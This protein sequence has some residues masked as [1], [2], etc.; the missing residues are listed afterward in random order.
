MKQNAD[1]LTASEVARR[2]GVTSETV[3]R[4]A[5]EGKVEYL[6]LPSGGIRFPADQEILQRIPVQGQ[7]A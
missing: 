1:L 3:R 5:R 2:S 7:T 4:W 6:R